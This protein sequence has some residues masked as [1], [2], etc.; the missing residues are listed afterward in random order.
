LLAWMGT[1]LGFAPD[2]EI[3]RGIVDRKLVPPQFLMTH[4]E[5]QA[6]REYYIEQSRIDYK[7]PEPAPKPPVSRLFQPEAVQIET[8]IIS[9]VGIDAANLALLIGSSR[10]AA[11]HVLTG[12]AKTSIAVN[13]EPV[14]YERIGALGRV[15]LMGDLGTDVRRGSIVDFDLHAAFQTNLVANHPRIAAHRTADVD[16]DGRDDLLVVGFGDYPGGRIGI[17]WNNDGKLSEQL[18]SEESGAVWGDIADLDGDGD[19][20]VIVTFANNH[21]RIVAYVNEGNRRLVSRTIIERPIGWGYNRCLLVDW[22]NDGDLDI[23]ECAGNNLE[24]RG[25]PIKAHH[26]IRVLRNDGNWQFK[27][28]LFERLDG[29]MDV[30]AG[31][32]N[33]D[34]RTDLAATAFYLDWRQPTPT[35]FLLLLQKPDGSVERSTIDD[36]FWNRW[37]RI[38]AG[39][40]DGDG[41]IDIVLGA[42]EVQMGI[43]SEAT[44]RFTEL[45][46][47]KAHALLLRNL[48][49]QERE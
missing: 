17:W 43:P 23:V 39:D 27:E 42:A 5:F 38:A 2:I 9:M 48:S 4:E 45:I 49:A 31:D 6:I 14:T 29:A 26:G 11:L 41:D 22:D 25:R 21:P 32:F 13:S 36:R 10:P 18:L 7:T 20:D 46:Q 12:G 24:L 44:N 15:A 16:G 30:V 33:G 19:R 35:T 40:A 47:N 28:M 8:P 37:M 34:G 1:Y 3:N